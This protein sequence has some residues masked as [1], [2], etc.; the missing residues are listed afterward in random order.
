[1]KFMT[2]LPVP[3]I[4]IPVSGHARLQLEYTNS[5]FSL[6]CQVFAKLTQ[7]ELKAL[8]AKIGN[9]SDVPYNAT[10][11]FSNQTTIDP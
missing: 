3:W 6:H 5:C 11:H 2:M 4:E 1:M 8:R 9:E 10:D 7:E